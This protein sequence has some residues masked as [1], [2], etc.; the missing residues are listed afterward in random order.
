LSEFFSLLKEAKSR[1]INSDDELLSILAQIDDRIEADWKVEVPHP[2]LRIKPTVAMT[3][4]GEL[5]EL[6]SWTIP[7][8]VHRFRRLLGKD[9]I[10]MPLNAYFPDLDVDLLT[11]SGSIAEALRETRALTLVEE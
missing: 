2:W 8:A 1:P 11:F 9:E 5:D 7:L 6:T 10:L 3:T 4:V